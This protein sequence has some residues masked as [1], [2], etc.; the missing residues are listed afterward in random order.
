LDIFDLRYLTASATAG[1]FAQAAKVLGLSTSTVSHRVGRF[2]DELGVTLFE[3]GRSGVR[4]SGKAAM[5]HVWRAL[6]E[7]E[8]VQ[9]SGRQIDSGEA[10]EIR[11]ELAEA[12]SGLYSF[13]AMYRTDRP[14]GP[15][16]AWLIQR[17]V[18][19]ADR[20]SGAK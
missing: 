19:Q 1:N 8:A 15:A 7:L 17:F 14:P 3:R 2:E 6:A 18:D 4:L 12:R 20:Q 13:Q 9:R 16:T 11:L 5:R 10:G